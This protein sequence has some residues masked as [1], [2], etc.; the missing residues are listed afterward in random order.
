MLGMNIVQGNLSIAATFYALW[1][2]HT[3]NGHLINAMGRKGYGESVTAPLIRELK[4]RTKLTSVWEI[5]GF[6]PISAEDLNLIEEI[7]QAR[8]A[9]VHYKWP[10]RDFDTETAITMRLD[11]TIS[12]AE[13]LVDVF[14]N[15]TSLVFW[16]DREDEV[17]AELRSHLRMANE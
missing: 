15:A 6:R 3:T 1:I 2:E 7:S 13:S 12:R 8:N 4:L 11:V 14:R 9:F 5:S 17:I 10:A 16:N